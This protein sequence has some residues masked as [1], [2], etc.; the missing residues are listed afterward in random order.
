MTE[1]VKWLIEKAMEAKIGRVFGTYRQRVARAENLLKIE[2]GELEIC[3]NKNFPASRRDRISIGG[4][5]HSTSKQM[6]RAD[7]TAPIT[8]RR[9]EVNI[10]FRLLRCERDADE[11]KKEP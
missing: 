5:L 8:V 4:Q 2:L 10:A 1:E 11:N 9:H 3:F 6:F 7:R